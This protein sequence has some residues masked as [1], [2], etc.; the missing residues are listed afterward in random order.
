MELNLNSQAR[1]KTPK[2]CAIIPAYNEGKHIVKFIKALFKELLKLSSKVE[3]IIVDDGSK[4]DTVKCITQ[5]QGSVPFKL[6]CLSRNFGKEK[7]VSAGLDY[8]DADVT[9]IIDGDFQ[10]PLETITKLYDK[11]QKG[12][13]NVYAVRSERKGQPFVIRFFSKMFYKLNKFVMNI[14]LPENAGDFRML[15]RKVVESLQK[16]TERNRFMKGLYAWVGFPSIGIKY[17]VKPRK[18]GS[19]KWGFFRLLD[20]AVTGITSFSNLPLRIWTLIGCL[21]SL[22]SFIYGL[23]ILIETVILGVSIPGFATITCGMFF[24]GGIQLIS[25]GV[26]AEYIARIFEEVKGRPTYIVKAVLESSLK[27]NAKSKK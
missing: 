14:D 6:I 24:L 20:L 17:N 26:V 5:I 10:H 11:W 15:D 8:A 21:I 23:F 4:D 3:L 1:P 19:S 13:D 12:Y 9:L 22:L 18:H 16:M 25:I 2:I 7:A 27:P